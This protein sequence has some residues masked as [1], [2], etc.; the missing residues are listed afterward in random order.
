MSTE[1]RQRVVNHSVAVSVGDTYTVARY[2]GRVFHK[3]LHNVSKC[4]LKITVYT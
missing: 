2:G 1:K 3:Y 4:S